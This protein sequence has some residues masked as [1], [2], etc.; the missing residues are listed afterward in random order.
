[1]TQI[2]HC[3]QDC[4]VIYTAGNR[5][6]RCLACNKIHKK[7]Y[8]YQYQKQYQKQYQPSNHGKMMHKLW[9]ASE[10]GKLKKRQYQQSE[11]GKAVRRKYLQSDKGRAYTEHD[12]WKRYDG[13]PEVY[14]FRVE[15]FRDETSC[16]DCGL[17]W[18]DGP[19]GVGHEI[20][21]ILAL[22]LG[23]TNQ[24]SNLQVLCYECHKTKTRFDMQ[25]LKRNNFA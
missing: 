15:A 11:R 16:I 4:G 24:R 18:I 23:G 12:I 19:R 10:R 22:S 21:H 14:T 7:R 3:C 1:M 2:E 9:L 17:A 25:K 13:M 20:D 6:K 5:S 8:Q